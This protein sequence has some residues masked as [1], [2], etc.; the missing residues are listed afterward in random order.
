MAT[1]KYTAWTAG[2]IAAG[3]LVTLAMAPPLT[4]AEMLPLSGAVDSEVLEAQRAKQDVGIWQMSDA[5]TNAYMYN[6]TVEESYSGDNI[7]GAG[8][9]SDIHGIATVIQNS[10]HNVIIQESMI[11]NVNVTP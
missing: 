9:L 11:L 2:G 1:D 8:A 3:L 7:L 5:A 6:T 4:H 10:G